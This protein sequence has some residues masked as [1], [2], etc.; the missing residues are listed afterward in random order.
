MKD[1]FDKNQSSNFF[2]KL[3]AI[4]T[5]LVVGYLLMFVF[6]ISG[7]RWGL[8]EIAA[9][10]ILLL[11]FFAVVYFCFSKFGKP[12]NFRLAKMHGWLTVIP[13]SLFLFFEMTF[14][15]Y[16]LYIWW[17]NFQVNPWYFDAGE[18]FFYF[19]LGLFLTAQL[20]FIWNILKTI[21]TKN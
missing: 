1:L 19:F 6:K 12:L 21:F 16:R 7:I 11:L 9:G 3:I 14:I 5:A 15:L 13:V 2:L 8:L 18:K 17:Y 4:P 10:L 20:I